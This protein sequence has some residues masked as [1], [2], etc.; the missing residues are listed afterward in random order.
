MAVSSCLG[1]LCSV[2]IIVTF[3][4]IHFGALLLVG[5]CEML[6]AAKFCC[7]DICSAAAL[8]QCVCF[9]HCVCY[10]MHER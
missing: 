5:S 3:S 7:S 8:V 4:N 9:E 6:N 2:S 10:M 1:Y